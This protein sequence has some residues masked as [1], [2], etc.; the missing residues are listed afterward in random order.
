MDV[1]NYSGPLALLE[2]LNRQYE[3]FS[4]DLQHVD[5]ALDFCL[6]AW[7][8]TDWTFHDTYPHLTSGKTKF[9]QSEKGKIAKQLGQFRE[10]LYRDCEDLKVTGDIA[11]GTKHFKLT[12]TPKTDI[13][14]I[15]ETV[16]NALDMVL[17]SGIDVP[18]L[19]LNFNDGSWVVLNDV[20]ESVHKFWNRHLNP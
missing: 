13:K 7:S 20:I 11:N 14:S 9:S 12:T 18:Q 17:D 15:E 3:I 16:E 5:R 2:R 8:L 4:N 19:R 10:T 1:F 6:T